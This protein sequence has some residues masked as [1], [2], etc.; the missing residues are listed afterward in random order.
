MDQDVRQDEIVG[1][2]AGGVPW[3]V[4][5]AVFVGICLVYALFADSSTLWDRDEPR[6]AR[7]AWEMYETGQYVVPHF[8]GDFRLHKPAGVYWLMNLGIEW[9]GFTELAFRLPSVIGIGL[10]S[11]FTFFIGRRLFSAK[12]GLWGMIIFPTMLVPLV[13]GS[14]TAATA[15]GSLIAAMTLAIW[16]VI[17]IMYCAR[18]WHYVVL[19]VALGAAWLLKGP[20]GFAVPALMMLGAVFF[21]RGGVIKLKKRTWVALV[22]ASL[23]GLGMF[24]AWGIPANEMTDGEF[25][26][27]GIG[28][29]VMARSTTAFESHGG[30][31]LFGYLAAIPAYVPVVIVGVSPWVLFLPLG[32]SGLIRGYIGKAKSR[33]VLWGWMV[34]PFVMFSLVATKL[35]HYIAP[36]F[37]AI[38]LMMAAAIEA[39]VRK[40]SPEDEVGWLDMGKWIYLVFLGMAVLGGIVGPWVL[41]RGSVGV[42]YVLSLLL[43]GATVW[44][45]MMTA[46]AV[47]SGRLYR[48]SLLTALIFPVITLPTVYVVMPQVEANFKP[49]KQIALGIHE[50]LGGED[51]P[52]IMSG[53]EEPSLV[54]Y[55]RRP[56]GEVVKETGSDTAAI[57]EWSRKPGTGILIVTKKN[58][59][60]TIDKYTKLPLD[61][62][63]EDETVNYSANRKPLDVMV[64]GRNMTNAML[65]RAEAFRESHELGE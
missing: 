58:Y 29:H 2:E 13:I 1:R 50:I 14:F 56:A 16:M 27:E 43:A 49:S 31:G 41:Q 36:I 35:P 59:D 39:R 37:P 4:V 12:T 51:V 3:W 33:A 25:Y 22:I 45:M 7:S 17:E 5:G 20:V 44:V 30:S 8:N 64:F 55:I 40:D 34:G 63:F 18:W 19:S 65:G 62:L 46:K 6:F 11:L 60:K 48:A 9:L 21:G 52:I 26:R 47:M 57:Y 54:F 32:L 24:V 15:D 10:T 38:A 53:Y 42:S 28:K 61:L 23:V